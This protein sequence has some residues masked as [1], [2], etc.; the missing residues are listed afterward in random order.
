MSVF[1]HIQSWIKRRVDLVFSPRA[2]YVQARPWD[3]ELPLISVV[4]PCYNHGDV[5]EGAVDSVLEGTW[6]DVEILVVNDGSEDPDTLSSLAAFSRPKSRVMDHDRN[7]GL[8]AARNTGISQARGKYI[9]C[10]DADDKLHPT[11]LEKAI[12][13]LESNQGIDL[14]YAWTQVFGDEDRVWY[15]PQFDPA[16]IIHHNQLNPPGVFRRAAWE[17]VGGFREEM[18]QGYEDWEFWIRLARAGYRG[19][20]IP[21]KLIYVRREGRSFIHQAQERH[22]Q[23]VRDIQHYNPDVYEDDSWLKYV[24][25]KTGNVYVREPF[26]NIKSRISFRT[27][28]DP[29]L[30][31]QREAPRN[32]K[33]T[34]EDMR[35]KNCQHEGDLVV[36]CTTPV[37]EEMQDLLYGETAYVYILP[38]FLPRYVWDK[39]IDEVMIAL[40]GATVVG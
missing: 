21:E 27:L 4:I 1:G 10:L 14:V 20:R 26:L 28:K 16:E 11:Y 19:Y 18:R 12:C 15:A 3:P 35:H 22:E 39:F 31:I 24:A 6:Q 8:P 37:E 2:S 38:H 25:R 32:I 17:D 36:V 13:L 34:I 7:Q 30:W 33:F 40:R 9:C 23:L 29:L 5:L